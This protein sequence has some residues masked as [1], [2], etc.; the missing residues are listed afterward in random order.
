ME[1]SN[2]LLNEMENETTYEHWIYI[3]ICIQRDRASERARD[4]YVIFITLCP[5]RLFTWARRD[6]VEMSTCFTFI[7]TEHR[8]PSTGVHIHIPI[9]T[10]PLHWFLMS[11]KRFMAFSVRV[12]RSSH[13]N[14]NHM[15]KCTQ[16]HENTCTQQLRYDCVRTHR[17]QT[18]WTTL[19]KETTRATVR[20][21]DSILK[22]SDI[23]LDIF[24]H[25]SSL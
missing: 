16:A 15:P 6:I 2:K 9:H 5:R 23:I 19:A 10:K 13:I 21:K 17:E 12:I 20:E 4:L 24:R 8:S 7:Q 1:L 18:N 14:K 22:S 3:G 11:A 25:F